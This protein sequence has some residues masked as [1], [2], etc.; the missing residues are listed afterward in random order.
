MGE[1]QIPFGA[2]SCAATDL[3]DRKND[4]GNYF[5]GIDT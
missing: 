1:I 4:L 2:V 3:T 5:L